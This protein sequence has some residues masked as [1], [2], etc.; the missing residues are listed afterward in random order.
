MLVLASSLDSTPLTV[1][2]SICS[3]FGFCSSEVQSHRFQRGANYRQ[4]RVRRKQGG[5]AICPDGCPQLLVSAPQRL[6]LIHPYLKNCAACR[7]LT[8]ASRSENAAQF[9][10]R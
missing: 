1:P 10:S 6:C 3:K 8:G 4:Y 5:G 9:F 7:A 2:A